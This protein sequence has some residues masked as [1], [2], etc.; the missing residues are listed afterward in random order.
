MFSADVACG[1]DDLE[2]MLRRESLHWY[3][4]VKKAGKDMVLEALERL[5]VEGRRP[6]GRPQETW[7]CTKE[8]LA[9]LGMDEHGAETE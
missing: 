4:H 6:L 8:D 9:L 7:R 2:S 3:G 5:E 1:V